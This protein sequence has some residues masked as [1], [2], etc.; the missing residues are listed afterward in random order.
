MKLNTL[1]NLHRQRGF[2]LIEL[3]I[4]V[5]IIGILAAIALPSYSEYVKRGH[6]TEAR[7]QLLKSAQYMQRFYASNDRFDSDR[8]G[9]AVALPTNLQQSPDQGSAVYNL[10]VATTASAYTLTATPVSPGSMAS[11]SCG[12]LILNHTN[13]KSISGSTST[14]VITQCWK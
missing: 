9:N 3:M 10:S 6:R 13:L 4:T 2:T 8:A 7:A 12:N 11:D 1:P 5:A 14:V